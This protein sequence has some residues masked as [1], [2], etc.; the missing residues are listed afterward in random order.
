MSDGMTRT[1]GR[2]LA[3]AFEVWRR[4]KRVSYAHVVRQSG[5]ARN[6]IDRIRDGATHLPERDTLRRLAKG[7]AADPYPPYD[8]DHDLEG[9]ITREF[10]A[11]CGY[12]PLDDTTAGELLETAL[13]AA[14]SSPARARAWVRA[15]ERLAGLDVDEIERLGRDRTP[16]GPRGVSTE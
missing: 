1:S 12:S 13:R 11:I 10:F 6:T 5:V 4:E 2:H 14:V 8:Q 9:R 3:T 15:I 7:L 16:P